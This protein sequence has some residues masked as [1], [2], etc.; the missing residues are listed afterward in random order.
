MAS[1][2]SG[3]RSLRTT[4]VV[5]G[6]V[7]VES[8]GDVVVA[9]GRVESLTA[10]VPDDPPQPANT[11]AMVKHAATRRLHT[12][13][14]FAEDPRSCPVGRGSR[15]PASAC[16]KRCP[17]RRTSNRSR[18]ERS[19][20]IGSPGFGRT[21]E[22][23]R[24]ASTKLHPLVQRRGSRDLYHSALV[25]HVPE[26]RFVIEQTPVPDQHGER[27]GVVATGPVGTRW[28]GRFRVFR[29]EIRRWLDGQIP[30]IHEAVASPVRVLADDILVA[31][32]AG[33]RGVGAD[34]SGAATSYMPA[35]CGTRTRSLPGC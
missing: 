15:S 28:A 8:G 19:I 33:G 18:V 2:A 26:G 31:R 5:V 34:R 17:T 7:E 13:A 30:D 12:T 1:N 11:T 9:R 35:R 6:G 16:L 4:G 14:N 20:C 32:R 23:Q 21:C 25:V 10:S 27:R 29:Y 22:A 24:E 3:A